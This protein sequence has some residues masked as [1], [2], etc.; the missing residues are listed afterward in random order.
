MVV[1]PSQWIGLPKHH[2]TLASPTKLKPP[3]GVNGHKAYRWGGRIE[4]SK[5]EKTLIISEQPID[6]YS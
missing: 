3:K 6:S 4:A 2:T 5:S 1:S